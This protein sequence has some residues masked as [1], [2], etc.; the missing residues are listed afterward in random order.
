MPRE[1]A[2][3]GGRWACDGHRGVPLAG[4]TCG[5]PRGQ[6]NRYIIIPVQRQW[7]YGSFTHTDGLLI[8]AALAVWF[9]YFRTT[10]RALR[11]G[12]AVLAPCTVVTMIAL[13][14]ALGESSTGSFTPFWGMAV[15][16]L[17]AAAL[18]AHLII[19][20]GAPLS[21]VLSWRPLVWIGRRSYGI[22]VF[23]PPILAM[24]HLWYTRDGDRLVPVA[25]VLTMVVA[26]LSYRFYE[27]PFLR[28][29]DRFGRPPDRRVA[30]SDAA[31]AEPVTP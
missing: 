5:V 6:L 18:V 2:V 31:P 19:S 3:G 15:F 22:Y 20:P 14:Y 10:G 28:L 17:S 21:R 1:V 7:Y 26:G 4:G 12:L 30:A 27:S 13:M 29:K 16:N 25:T 11:V 24:L 9:V 8:G 23:N